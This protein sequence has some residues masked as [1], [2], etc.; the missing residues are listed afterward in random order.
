MPLMKNGLPPLMKRVPLTVRLPG[1]SGAGGSAGPADVCAQDWSNAP[2][3]AAAAP[4]RTIRLVGSRMRGFV[5]RGLVTFKR[6]RPPRARGTL[7]AEMRT[8]A[9]NVVM[10]A[11]LVVA[12]AA[13]AAEAPAP[14]PLGIS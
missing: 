12:P 3:A 4:C 10:F 2:P 7:A 9:S 14:A 1:S 6:L 11:V 5:A 8:I 13:R